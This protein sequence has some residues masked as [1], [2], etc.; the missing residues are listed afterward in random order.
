MGKFDPCGP[1]GTMFQNEK[2][3]DKNMRQQYE[4]IGSDRDAQRQWKTQ[5]LRKKAAKRR[6]IIQKRTESLQDASGLRGEY[7]TIEKAWIDDGGT[8]KS[9]AAVQR[10][11]LNN[12][13]LW[14]QGARFRGKEYIKL[15]AQKE[16]IQ[17]LELTEYVDVHQEKRYST[18]ER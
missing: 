4:E 12:L 14:H 3:R 6:K 10:M 15:N 2:R 7:K 1:I 17:I 16:C 18:A 11:L 13:R 5:W 9:W 8:K